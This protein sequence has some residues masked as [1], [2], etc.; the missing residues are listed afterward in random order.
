MNKQGFSFEWASNWASLVSKSDKSWTF[1]NHTKYKKF[2]KNNPHI[3]I[4][5][6]PNFS[7]LLS[8]SGYEV[9]ISTIHYVNTLTWIQIFSIYKQSKAGFPGIILDT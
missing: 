8:S 2:I 1:K 7:I 6:K 5:L 4:L 9:I 3:I